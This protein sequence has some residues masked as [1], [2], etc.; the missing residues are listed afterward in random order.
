MNTARRLTHLT[1][2]AAL[3][4]AAV[5]AAGVAD[6]SEAPAA[7][8]PM[9]TVRLDTVVVT[10]HRGPT[11]AMPIVELPTVVVTGKRAAD[12]TLVAAKGAKST[13]PKV[14]G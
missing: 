3:A 5:M 14:A 8:A 1:M 11:D 10:G 12:S 13:A 7:V 4:A 9:K 6:R 2:I